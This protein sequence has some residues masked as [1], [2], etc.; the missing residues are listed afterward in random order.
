M[1]NKLELIK[2]THRA[3][4]LRVFV[5]K[6]LISPNDI[7]NVLAGALVDLHFELYHYSI[8]SKNVDSFNAK[9]EQVMVLQPGESRPDTIYKR[10]M[11]EDGPIWMN[12]A[13][14]TVLDDGP[15]LLASDT[16]Q[17]TSSSSLSED[18][19]VEGL[20]GASPLCSNLLVVRADHLRLESAECPLLKKKKTSS[21]N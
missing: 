8:R 5:E 12:P 3:V 14:A 2:K 19:V 11:A 7:C 21:D 15:P 1:Q 4:P 16:S 18:A 10:S 17:I 20:R 6:R 13:L 9:I